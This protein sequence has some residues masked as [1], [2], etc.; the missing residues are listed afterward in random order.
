MVHCTPAYGCDAREKYAHTSK[1]ARGRT[2]THIDRHT[3]IHAHITTAHTWKNTC[4]SCRMSSPFKIHIRWYACARIEATEVTAGTCLQPL[5]SQSDT[6]NS[7]RS[8][9]VSTSTSPHAIP[10]MHRA[11]HTLNARSF[12]PGLLHTGLADPTCNTKHCSSSTCAARVCQVVVPPCAAGAC[13][14][15]ARSPCSSPRAAAVAAAASCEPCSRAMRAAQWC[16]CGRG[17]GSGLG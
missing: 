1:N 10:L 7:L 11:A 8:P 5:T 4:T 6:Y 14:Q 13:V 2:H 12:W 15:R 3:H 16:G 17:S 9:R